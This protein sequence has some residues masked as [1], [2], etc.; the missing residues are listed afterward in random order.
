[1]KLENMV[2]DWRLWH[3]VRHA[4]HRQGVEGTLMW[5]NP[6]WTI[7]WYYESGRVGGGW[8]RRAMPGWRPKWYNGG[9]GGCICKTRRKQGWNGREWD[10]KGG[11]GWVRGVRVLYHDGPDSCKAPQ[12][13]S[14]L[15]ENVH[16]DH[17]VDRYKTELDGKT[18]SDGWSA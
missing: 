10:P 6:G 4:W 18:H 9:E 13:D 3:G 14:N 11:F 8:G 12:F 5:T 2:F 1:M 16:L 17:R 15:R 7:S